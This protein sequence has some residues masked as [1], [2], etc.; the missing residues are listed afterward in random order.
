MCS[1][2]S[3]I[4]T[5]VCR[6]RTFWGVADEFF[7]FLSLCFSLFLISLMLAVMGVVSRY[8]L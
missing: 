3:R 2:T 4:S 1:L 8:S 7:P 5:S 6:G